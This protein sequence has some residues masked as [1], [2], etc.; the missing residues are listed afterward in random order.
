MSP[1]FFFLIQFTILAYALV[2]GVF[3]A[4]SDFIMR[5]LALTRGSGG[6]E[7]MQVINREVFRWVFMTLF[8]GTTAVSL[9]IAGYGALGLSGPAGTLIMLAGLVYLV[10]CFCVTVFFNVPMNKALAGMNLS[11]DSTRD[12]WRQTYLPRWTF[13]NSVR[14]IACAIS[15]AMLLFGLPWMIQIQTQPA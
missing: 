2:G 7:A 3:L 1:V 5:S 10:G 13:W 6:V 8:L 4:F 11:S 9:V 12:Y 15:A 14:T